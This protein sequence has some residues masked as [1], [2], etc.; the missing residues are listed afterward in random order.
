VVSPFIDKRHGTE[1]GLVEWLTRLESDY[2]IHLY[3][4]RVE[5][6][7]LPTFTWHR[8]P[9]L[10]GPHLVNYLWWF[11]ANHFYRW[12][13]RRFH[14]LGFD[15]VFTPGVNC[16]DADVIAVYIVFAEFYRQTRE[17]LRFRA[18][19]P[20]FWPRLLHRRLYYGLAKW[21]ERK[22][23]TNPRNH[24][25]VIARKTAK[26]IKTFY[27]REDDFQVAYI[28]LDHATFNPSARKAR[29]QQIREELGLPEAS[30][31]L[32]LIGNDWKKKGLSAIIEALL[33]LKPL[34]ITLLVVGQDD[35]TPFLSKIHDYGLDTKVRF[36]PPRSEVIAYYSAA[37]AYVG[38]SLEDTFAFPPT[39][40]MGTGLPVITTATNG[41]SEIMT[42]GVDGFVLQDP[43]DVPALADLIERL[44]RDLQLRQRMG[45]AAASTT[46]QYTWDRSADI[47][48][49][50]LEEVL[51][52]KLEKSS[53]KELRRRLRKLV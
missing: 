14:G 6:M 51:R 29:R 15:L 7:D 2:D 43:T 4:Q 39:E 53:C 35:R 10:P 52:T 38:P 25:F 42:H 21:L 20:R 32:L 27:E 19:T 26:D 24:L 18:N 33:R 40:A 49:S 48:G 28:G 36:L 17:E 44:Y 34:P 11:A 45:E 13:D 23:Y 41:T 8:I 46:Q 12:R 5:D 37:D 16:F 47:V 3:S 1:R 9:T 30:F 31:V 22:I 50:V